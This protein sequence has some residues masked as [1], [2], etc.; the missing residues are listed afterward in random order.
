MTSADDEDL[1]LLVR[2]L[3]RSATG[4][5]S[6]I[7]PKGGSSPALDPAALDELLRRAVSL[8]ASDLLIV[9]DYPPAFRVDGAL[10]AAEHAPLGPEEIRSLAK[11]LLDEFHFREFQRDKA[12]DFLVERAG[13]GR[14]RCDLHHQRGSIAMTFRVL[15]EVTPAFESLNLPSAVERF[16]GLARGLVLFCG[17]T[18]CG[19]S[20]TM[21][22]LIGIMNRTRA[23]HVVTIEDPVEYSHA[24]GTCVIEQVEI[25][26]DAVS[27]ATALRHALRQNPD[28]L[29]VGEMRDLE[30]IGISLTAAETGHL[31]F[32]TLHTND[33]AGTID[34]LID[35]FPDT[36]QNQVR[37]QVSLSLAGVVVQRLVPVSGGKGRVPA[38]EI[39]IANDPVRNLIRT[40]RNHLLYSQMTL[41]RKEGMMTMEDSLASLVKAGTIERE[42]ALL[43]AGRREELEK[44]LG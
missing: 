16:A 38:C 34:R 41:G 22:A 21:G 1:R 31:V 18:G 23:A 42:E 4:P 6:G 39:L 28:I 32:S 37:Q 12:S 19:K 2:Q 25:G 33:A 10:V 3:N 26:R 24:R 15:P 8:G 27:F 17:P 9:A 11:I 44:L 43:R 36:Q 5:A 20:T 13:I 40:G 14:F 7:S 30:S 29:L 35:V